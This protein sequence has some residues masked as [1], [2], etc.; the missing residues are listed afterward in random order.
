MCCTPLNAQPHVH[1]LAVTPKRRGMFGGDCGRPLSF[2]LCPHE[3]SC[4]ADAPGT[5]AG[6][7]LAGVVALTLNSELLKRGAADHPGAELRLRIE[8]LAQRVLPRS[9][10]ARKHLHGLLLP[11]ASGCGVPGEPCIA[12]M[13]GRRVATNA[14]LLGD[15][16]AAFAMAQLYGESNRVRHAPRWLGRAEALAGQWRKELSELGGLLAWSRIGAAVAPAGPPEGQTAS[17]AEAEHEG[18]TASE[19][20]AEPAWLVEAEAELQRVMCESPV[21]SPRTPPTACQ[22]PLPFALE[23]ACASPPLPSPEPPH[24]TPSSP[25]PTPP[26]PPGHVHM[27]SRVVVGVAFK[28]W[29]GQV[30]HVLVAQVLLLMGDVHRQEWLAQRLLRRW[31]GWLRA[32]HVS[33]LA[34]AAA[35]SAIWPRRAVA[36]ALARWAAWRRQVGALRRHVAEAERKWRKQQAAA[37]TIVS[38]AFRQ[39]R[40]RRCAQIRAT[41]RA[42]RERQVAAAMAIAAAVRRWDARR[43]YQRCLWWGL[44][45]MARLTYL[46]HLCPWDRQAVDDRARAAAGAAARAARLRPGLS[47]DVAPVTGTGEPAS[48]F[49]F[50]A[51]AQPAEPRQSGG[52]QRT[53]RARCRRRQRLEALLEAAGGDG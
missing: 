38:N 16:I 50:T 10:E 28:R 29:S 18:R 37:A 5:D 48:P 27:A 49:V 52:R 25:P 40:A 13:L 14:Q 21:S 22:S 34:A 24:A 2:R 53:V 44:D 46:E 9:C 47:P 41:A 15:C 17:E 51:T 19:A 35:R 43:R 31:A 6:D 30:R 11:S 45:A 1:T 12:M 8:V 39:G 7:V 26:T 23:A 42:V 32:L 4:S 3:P 36:A 33:R 20:E